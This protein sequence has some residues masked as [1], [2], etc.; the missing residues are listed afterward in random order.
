[1]D[2]NTILAILAQRFDMRDTARK[3]TLERRKGL[4]LLRDFEA[5]L[6]LRAFL[7]LEAS[8]ERPG[9][10]RRDGSWKREL[11]ETSRLMMS[12]ESWRVRG[13]EEEGFAR[14]RGEPFFLDA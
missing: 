4:N 14:D 5:K 10:R 13:L 1:M 7:Q 12:S 2:A 8:S 6:Q 11:I 9:L 3:I